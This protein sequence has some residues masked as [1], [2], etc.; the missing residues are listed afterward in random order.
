MNLSLKLNLANLYPNFFHH[1]NDI[2]SSIVE[3]NRTI[4][5]FSGSNAELLSKVEKFI[6]LYENKHNEEKLIKHAIEATSSSG[7]HLSLVDFLIDIL[8]K[9][10]SNFDNVISSS[11]M[12]IVHEFYITI[13]ETVSK[14]DA[15]MNLCQ[16]LKQKL[17]S[18]GQNFNRRSSLTKEFYKSYEQ[19]LMKIQDHRSTFLNLNNIQELKLKNVIQLFLQNELDLSRNTTCSRDCQYYNNQKY[20]HDGCYGSM[21][22]CEPMIYGTDLYYKSVSLK[23]NFKGF[24]VEKFIF[25]KTK[26]KESTKVLQLNEIGRENRAIPR[27]T[28]GDFRTA[29]LTTLTLAVINHA[30]MIHQ[31]ATLNFN[32]TAKPKA[33]HCGF[34]Q[35]LRCVKNVAVPAI[36]VT[37][38]LSGEFTQ[39]ELMHQMGSEF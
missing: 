28:I 29:K 19:S 38:K 27:L 23:L 20:N 39:E 31:S 8:K 37:K 2:K 10:E 6:N 1:F 33:T 3:F 26:R 7:S 34:Y 32:R 11:P 17:E 16:I 22:N 13:I 18:S 15:M 21:H 9:Q 25:R 30:A 12:Q 24:Q 4:T 36:K 14:S 5:K 35:T